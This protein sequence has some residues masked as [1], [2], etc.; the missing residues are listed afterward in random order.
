MLEEKFLGGMLGSALGDAVGQLA[1]HHSRREDLIGRIEEVDALI[2]T[3]DTAMAI[4]IAQSLSE[5]GR[6][7]EKHLGDTFRRNFELEP[8]RGYG[9][10]PPA[11][12]RMVG[13]SGVCYSSAAESLFGG[14]GS[15]G[16]GASMR[17]TPLALFF[18][19]SDDLY[20]AVE[21]SARITHTHPLGIDGAAVLAKAIAMVV[22]LDPEEDFP[23]ID[24]CRQLFDFARTPEFRKK[25][26]TME[27]MLQNRTP[28]YVAAAQLGTD[29]TAQNSVP[30]AIFAFLKSRDSFEETIFN[31]VLS[32]GDRDTLGAM[33]GGISGA[34]LGINTIPTRWHKKLENREYIESLAHSLT[35]RKYN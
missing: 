17:I 15:F 11:I 23:L 28:L 12:F 33:A 9:F 20:S 8:W 10:G 19:D 26:R 3:D 6:I 2:Y 35:T 30:F 18:H 14:N 27:E 7:D 25:I 4:G 22:P 5:L 34:Y 21:M 13:K 24:F 32:G 16:N 1:F 31:A 29:T